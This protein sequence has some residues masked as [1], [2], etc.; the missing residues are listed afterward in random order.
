MN[1]KKH[2]FHL[3]CSGAISG[4]GNKTKYYNKQGFSGS[5]IENWGGF[6]SCVPGTVMRTN[7]IFLIINHSITQRYAGFLILPSFFLFEL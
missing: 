5:Y 7:Y 2:P 4:T 6:K 3:H 1:N